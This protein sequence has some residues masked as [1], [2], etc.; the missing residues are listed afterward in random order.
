M[1]RIY[2]GSMNTD[3]FC[4]NTL[5]SI[6]GGI[7]EISWDTVRADFILRPVYIERRNVVSGVLR[8]LWPTPVS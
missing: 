5:E 3:R 7:D 4:M 1:V 6:G 2:D 8:S